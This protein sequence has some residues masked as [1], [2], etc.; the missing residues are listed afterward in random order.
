[1]KRRPN[2]EIVLSAMKNGIEVELVG[3]TY[4]LVDGKLCHRLHSWTEG[5]FRTDPPDKILWA[6]S[7]L[8][9]NTFIQECEEL[10]ESTIVGL[11]FSST[12]KN[13]QRKR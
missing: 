9:L 4:T 10:D 11:V 6:E 7:D 3:A 8:P 5:D 13:M 2:Y 12:M 1:M